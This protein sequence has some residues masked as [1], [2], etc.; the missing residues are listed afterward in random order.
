MRDAVA[1]LKAL[2]G[3]WA[4]AELIGDGEKKYVLLPAFV[5]RNGNEPKTI[6]A[7]LRPWANG[8]GYTPRLFFSERFTA[9]GSNWNVFNI[10]GRTWHACSWQSVS[11]DLPWLEIVASH[12]RPLQ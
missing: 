5:V 11:E 7:L 3:C 4:D 2:R 6:T 1:E 9:K 8:D 12:L 10:L